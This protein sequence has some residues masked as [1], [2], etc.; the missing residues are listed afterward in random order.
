[1][2]QVFIMAS[3]GVVVVAF[4]AIGASTIVANA[5]KQHAAS[6]AS[7]VGAMDPKKH[8]TPPELAAENAF[9]R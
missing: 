8:S 1:M 3:I 9:P 5:P 4:A 2:R 6:A 7:W